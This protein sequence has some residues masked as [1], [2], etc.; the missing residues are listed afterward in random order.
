MNPDAKK[1]LP[2]IRDYLRKGRISKAER[3]LETALSGCPDSMHS[4]Q[5]LGEIQFYFDDIPNA[6]RRKSDKMGTAE[7]VVHSDY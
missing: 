6:R 7:I 5:T 2:Q 1:H 3:L 4:Y